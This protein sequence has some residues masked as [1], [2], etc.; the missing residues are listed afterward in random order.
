[1][2]NEHD[3][4]NPNGVCFC[5]VCRENKL[6]K[7]RNTQTGV[8]KLVLKNVFPTESGTGEIAQKNSRSCC[9]V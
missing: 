1:M 3:T 9:C 6:Q 2:E 7:Y 4:A 5:P 8:L